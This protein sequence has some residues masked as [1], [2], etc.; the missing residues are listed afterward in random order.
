[1]RLADTLTLLTLAILL[2]I[3]APLFTSTIDYEPH[4]DDVLKKGIW[5]EESQ[6]IASRKI[7]SSSVSRTLPVLQLHIEKLDQIITART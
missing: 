4:F 1:M 2:L 7:H 6:D 3:Q 5:F